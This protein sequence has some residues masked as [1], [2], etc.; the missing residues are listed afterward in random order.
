MQGINDNDY[1]EDI[2]IKSSC[3]SFKM[4]ICE[5]NNINKK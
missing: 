4:E 2:N 3:A 1:I 5:N